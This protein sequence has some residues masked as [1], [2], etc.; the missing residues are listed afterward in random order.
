MSTA[1][2]TKPETRMNPN[3]SSGGN[4]PAYSALREELATYS[5][6]SSKLFQNYA[7]QDATARQWQRLESAY[8]LAEVELITQAITDCDLAVRTSASSLLG[9]IARQNELPNTALTAICD[10][11]SRETDEDGR[12]LELMVIC[13]VALAAAS[14]RNREA[15]MRFCDEVGAEAQNELRETREFYGL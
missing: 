5:R 14:A 2:L 10:A 7:E 9:A 15:A 1:I 6:L 12:R 11:F 4:D 13:G 3:E 8:G